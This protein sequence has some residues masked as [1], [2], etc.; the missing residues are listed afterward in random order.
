MRRTEIFVWSFIEVK[1]DEV[2]KEYL[3]LNSKHFFLALRPQK[4]TFVQ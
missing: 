2:L 4:C 1:N 3:S